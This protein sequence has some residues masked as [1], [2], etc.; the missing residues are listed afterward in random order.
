[1]K[2]WSLLEELN[3]IETADETWSRGLETLKTFGVD[4]AIW[5]DASSPSAP[6]LRSD[7]PQDWLRAY[8]HD[9][10]AGG[11]PFVTYCLASVGPV[12]TGIEYLDRYDYLTTREKSFIAQ[13]SEATGTRSG[14]SVTTV[15]GRAG[16]NLMSDMSRK[17]FEA[18]FAAHGADVMLCAQM[19]HVSL[20]GHT[21]PAVTLSRRERDCLT[22]VATGSRMTEIAERLRIAE[23]TVELHLRNARKRLGARTRDEA[24]AR[25]LTSGAI[26]L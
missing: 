26:K 7:C 11:D 13:A 8:G 23:S 3:K 15:R 19:I 9:I 22:Y 16:W 5:M 4:R 20:A 2:A 1:M 17:E 10:S 14:T 21:P 6:M 24:V 18:L 12:R 25:A